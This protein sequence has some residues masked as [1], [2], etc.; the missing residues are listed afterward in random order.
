QDTNV[1]GTVTG[2]QYTG[3]QALLTAQTKLGVKPR[4]LGAPGL[5]TQAV[6]TALATTAQALRGFVYAACI[7][8]D[9]AEC[10]TYQ[11]NFSARELMLLW[12]DFQAFDVTASA[13]V[14]ATATARALGLRAKIDQKIGWHKTLSNVPVN[15]VT[16]IT[17]PVYWDLQQ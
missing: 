17:Q 14:T 11:Q 13:T 16:G 4:I 15:G 8:T 9:V 7:G 3:L 12:P 5:D 1:I 6:T 10:L 2:G